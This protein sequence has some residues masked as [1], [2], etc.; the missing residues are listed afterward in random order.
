MHGTRARAL[1][2]LP[3][4]IPL[5]HLPTPITPL[6]RLCAELGGPRIDVKRDDLTGLLLSGNKVRKLEY[7]MADARQQGATCVITCG[8]IQSNHARATAAAAAQL[9]LRCVLAL[10]GGT[11]AQLQTD[12]DPATP[13]GN[14][15]LDRLLGAEVRWVSA[16]EYE[17]RGRVMDAFAAEV[18]Q[19]GEVPYIIPEGGSN[20]LGACGYVAMLAELLDQVPDFPWTTLVC[21]VGSGG[22]MAGLLI[23]ARLLGLPVRIRGYSVHRSP[24]YFV[25]E[26]LAIVAEYDR[27]YG[28]ALSLAAQ[29]I[30]VAGG[31]EGPGYAQVFPQEVQTILHLARQEGIVLDPVYTGKAFTGLLADIRRGAVA[32]RECV[33]F[34]HTGGV[35]GLFA[36]RDHFS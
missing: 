9:G 25:G 35:F 14:L 29:D 18:R 34:L 1:A 7:L 30:E 22:T 26:V 31:Y 5:A 8:G 19:A 15:F 36:Q 21:A 20:A 28:T 3:P 17:D 2:A 11:P 32:S 16:S 13:D 6:P 27:R 24:D 23:G 4:R 33:L 10:K 12:R